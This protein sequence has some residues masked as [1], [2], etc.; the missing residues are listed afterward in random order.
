[1]K[2]YAG[3]DA[4]NI[5]NSR[6]NGLVNFQ[7]NEDVLN[8]LDDDEE[9]GNDSSDD[10][11]NTKKYDTV[12]ECN[13]NILKNSIDIDTSLFVNSNDESSIESDPISPNKY[14]ES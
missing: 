7:T 12:E 9:S 10:D 2:I 6:R 13:S 1:M 14:S 3:V 5:T 11:S 8:E 4:L